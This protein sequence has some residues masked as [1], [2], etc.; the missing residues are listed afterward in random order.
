MQ[1]Y[2]SRVRSAANNI[3]PLA[4]NAGPPEFP[5]LM[6]ASICMPSRAVAPW[7]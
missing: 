4:L 6:A 7:L 1:H 2:P 5:A 3:K